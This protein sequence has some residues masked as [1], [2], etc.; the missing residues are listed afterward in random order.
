MQRPMQMRRRAATGVL[1]MASNNRPLT[2]VVLL[3]FFY[4]SY[5]LLNFGST[6]TNCPTSGRRFG[7]MFDAGSTGSRIHVFE[8]VF[9]PNNIKLE[10]EVFEQLKPG[11][12]SFASDPDAAARSLI[13]LLE[14]AMK[15]VPAD[16]RACTPMLLKA[17]AGLRL[18]GAD[19]S[20]AVLNAVR[21]LFA[22]YPFRLPSDAVMVMDGVDE[23]PYAWLTVNFLLGHFNTGATKKKT[24]G[25]M[26]LGGGSTQIVFEPDSTN[27]LRDAPAQYV[28][29]ITLFG[30]DYHLYQNSYLG[31]GLKEAQKKMKSR[32]G[33]GNVPCLPAA[34]SVTHNGNTLTGKEDATYEDCAAVAESILQKS[35]MCSRVPCSFFG[36]YQPPIT[37]T[38]SG[39]WYIF[40]YFY[41]L[42]EERIKQKSTDVFPLAELKAAAAEACAKTNNKGTMCMDHSFIYALLSHGY[43]LP[44]TTPVYLKKKINGIE[45]AWAL[46][47]MITEM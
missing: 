29:K 47:A 31:F 43:E 38:F 24:A 26:D 2:I 28:R 13:P 14:V 17:T 23:G 21:R 5:K 36:V 3:V 1:N 16:Q 15:E 42:M 33:S 10:R 45:T 20:E 11:L 37:K 18:V 44:D 6:A 7:I 22:T 40:S 30:Q 4:L 34:A 12:S 8:F 46:G 32:L 9:E 39:D 19:K 35:N 27:T 41:D 25:I